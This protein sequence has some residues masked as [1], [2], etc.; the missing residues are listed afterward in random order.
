[1]VR[2]VEANVRDL[3]EQGLDLQNLLTAQ[4]WQFCFI[5][6]IA[7]QRWSEPRFTKDLDLTILTGYARK[8]NSRSFC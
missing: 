5:G 8:S 6:G 1:M 2:K 4:G 7:V 3:V